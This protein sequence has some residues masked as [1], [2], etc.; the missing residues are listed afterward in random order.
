MFPVSEDVL[1]DIVIDPERDTYLANEERFIRKHFAEI[2]AESKKLYQ[3][4]YDTVKQNYRFL[5]KICCDFYQLE[6]AENAWKQQKE[7]FSSKC[8][9]K[10]EI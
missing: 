7:D 9:K 3:D 6:Q 10:Y 2:K 4:R 8:H 1:T 5:N